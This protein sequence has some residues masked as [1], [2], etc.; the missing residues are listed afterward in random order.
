MCFANENQRGE[1]LQD[2]CSVSLSCSPFSLV[3]TKSN[4]KLKQQSICFS[5]SSLGKRTRKLS[6]LEKTKLPHS[7]CSWHPCRCINRGCFPGRSTNR[8]CLSKWSGCFS[9][10]F[11]NGPQEGYWRLATEEKKRLLDESG[12]RNVLGKEGP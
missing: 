5:K 3:D 12:P 9:P 11:W 8:Y 6:W 2:N 1:N 4:V 7:H 10:G